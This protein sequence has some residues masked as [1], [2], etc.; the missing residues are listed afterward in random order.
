MDTNTTNSGAYGLWSNGFTTLA[1]QSIT[2]Q[3]F[4]VTSTRSC[5]SAVAAS[6]ASTAGIGRITPK[7]PNDQ[8][9]AA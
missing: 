5:S 4:L 2:S 3:T 7:R 1:P 8:Q 6:S 9:L